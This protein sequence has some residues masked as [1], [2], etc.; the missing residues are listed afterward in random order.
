MCQPLGLEQATPRK[1]GIFQASVLCEKG[2]GGGIL[3]STFA[4]V[5]GLCRSAYMLGK[6]STTEPQPVPRQ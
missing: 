5:G 6:C 2:L 4:G 3:F 1:T